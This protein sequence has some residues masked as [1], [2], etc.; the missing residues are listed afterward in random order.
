MHAHGMTLCA[1][2]IRAVHV[3]GPILLNRLP[4][5]PAVFLPSSRSSMSTLEDVAAASAVV[6]DKVTLVNAQEFGKILLA[7]KFE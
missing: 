6:T 5:H 3:H 7:D 1:L 4:P 2:L